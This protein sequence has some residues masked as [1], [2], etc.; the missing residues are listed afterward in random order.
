MTVVSAINTQ[1][2]FE[3]KIECLPTKCS[4]TALNVEGQTAFKERM[5]KTFLVSPAQKKYGITNVGHP[6]TTPDVLDAS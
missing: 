1:M 6:F 5:N 4:F 3:G 2:V